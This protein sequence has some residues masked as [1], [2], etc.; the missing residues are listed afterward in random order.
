MS[1]DIILSCDAGPSFCTWLIARGHRAKMGCSADDCVDGKWTT[2]D[3]GA[4]EIMRGLWTVYNIGAPY[5]SGVLKTPMEDYEEWSVA[6]ERAANRKINMFDWHSIGFSWSDCF[7][8]G[9]S[10]D[11][12]ADA[13]IHCAVTQ[14]L[15]AIADLKAGVR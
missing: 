12:A 10:V 3:E 5:L 9:Y 11:K 14:A 13:L 15:R 8:S 6:V 1:Y 7:E 2:A 4:Y